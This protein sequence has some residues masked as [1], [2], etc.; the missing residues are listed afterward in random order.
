MNDLTMESKIKDLVTGNE[1]LLFMKG[2]KEAPMC[3]FSAQVIS[4]LNVNKVEYNTFNILE[5]DMMREQVKLFTKW[6]TY[7]QL[8]IKG[9][10]VG[11]CDIITELHE[12]GEFQ[13]LFN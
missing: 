13:E 11:G 12:N 4:I 9:K 7:P 10:F 8:Y 2:K 5:D 3:R 1:V 6:P